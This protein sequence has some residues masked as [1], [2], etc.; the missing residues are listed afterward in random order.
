MSVKP[1]RDFMV[2]SVVKEDEKVAGGLL[3][4]PATAEEKVVQGKVLAVGSGYLT[5]G[6]TIVPL[7]VQVGDTI[8]FNKNYAVEIKASGETVFVLREEHVLCV[9]N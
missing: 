7:E 1:L 9:L 2:V 6:G 5:D 4:R 8:V 3:Y